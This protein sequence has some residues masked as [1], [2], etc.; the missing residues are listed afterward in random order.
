LERPS[1]ESVDEETTT[2]TPAT[3]PAKPTLKPSV[4]EA[5]ALRAAPVREHTDDVTRTA[6]RK[7]LYLEADDSETPEDM[8]SDTPLIVPDV[9][10][11][12]LPPPIAANWLPPR[13]E[14]ARVVTGCVA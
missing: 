12:T 5:A 13:S 10:R 8:V 11:A 1:E 2:E 3:V 14:I 4:A 7:T 9:T 6:L